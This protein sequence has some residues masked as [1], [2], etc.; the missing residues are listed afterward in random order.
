[1]QIK[2]FPDC[3]IVYNDGRLPENWTVADLLSRHRSRPYN[4]KLAYAFYR[5]GYIE[6][7]GR[8]IERITTACE[9]AGKRA[10][11]FHVSPSEVI[12]KFFTDVDIGENIGENIGESIGINETQSK[13]M[14]HMRAKPTISAKAIAAE[15]GISLRNV[16]VHIRSLKK[17]GLVERVGAAKGGYWV[18]K[19]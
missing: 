1:M 19:N 2:V 15:I 12:V 13:I 11:L 16:E 18:V 6:S 4:P 14:H 10:P 7:W 8:G 3:V 9:D 5:A 17:A